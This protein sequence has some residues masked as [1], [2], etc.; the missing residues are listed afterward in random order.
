MADYNHLESAC[1]FYAV[2]LTPLRAALRRFHDDMVADAPDAKAGIHGLGV[3]YTVQS[4]ERFV[5]RDGIVYKVAS[6]TVVKLRPPHRAAVAL[7]ESPV[8][9]VGFNVAGD[10]E[11][12]YVIRSTG[13]DDQFEV[14]FPSGEAGNP[15]HLTYHVLN[16]VKT[17]VLA[18][19]VYTDTQIAAV[20]DVLFNASDELQHL[21]FSH[22][23]RSFYRSGSPPDIALGAPGWFA[24]CDDSSYKS[25][26]DVTYGKE[27]TSHCRQRALTITD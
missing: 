7:D 2:P 18:N 3:F 9:D 23:L 11:K 4:P 27:A 20:N 8:V 19:S 26:D 24:E 12:D 10:V 6:R 13:R 17:Y 22:D 14:V 5:L 16:G 25:I 1:L 15:F 21:R